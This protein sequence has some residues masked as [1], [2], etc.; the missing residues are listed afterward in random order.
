LSIVDL[1]PAGA[2][3]MASA[4]GRF[5]IA[6]N[7][8]IYNYA[9]LRAQ[10][11][12]QAWRGHSDTEVLLAAME[13]FGVPGALARCTGMFAFALWDAGA[14]HLVIG[15]D[16]LGEKPLYYGLARDALLV[17]SELKAFEAWPGFAGEIDREALDDFMRRGCVHAPRSIYRNVRKLPAG[18]LLRIPASSARDVLSAAPQVYWSLAEHAARPPQAIAADVALESLDTLLGG[19][20][21][22]QMVADVP[23]GAFLSGG[24]DS[25][26]VVA[27]MQ[28]QSIRP[29]RTYSIG[30]HE[31]GF[32]EAH[33]AKAVAAHLGTEHI[34]LY[35]TA[36]E[37]RAVIP[38][39][40]A[41]FDEPF[42]DS[43]Q[44]PTFLVAELARRSVTVSLSGDGGDELFGGYN[45]YFWAQRIWARAARFPGFVRRAAGG[46]VRSVGIGT[47][48]RMG[49]ALP[50]GVRMPQLG[51]KLHKLAGLAAMGDGR[52]AYDWLIAQY[53][54]GER[55]VTDLPNA[56]S[57]V[58]HGLWGGAGRKLADDMMLADAIGYLPDD[59][60]VKVDRATMAVSLEARAPFLDHKL[61]EF[62]FSLPLE[63][64]IRDGVGKWLLRQLLFRHVPRELIERPKMGFGVPIDAW[65]RGPLK[66][67]AGDL[68][69]PDSLRAQGF[70][71]PAP[72]ARAW[73][74]HQSGRQNN[75]HFLWNALMFQAWLAARRATPGT[76]PLP[77]MEPGAPGFW[78][79]R[80][81][82]PARTGP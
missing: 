40:P 77:R 29:V 4:S 30:F 12:A 37:A 53:R 72:I 27:L 18:C 28:R 20:I 81:P 73:G 7:G 35:V 68:L 57:L 26:L 38:R 14:R 13:A 19:A 21:A 60:L 11:P 49:R 45:R 10:L 5:T 36:A 33:H 58:G 17:G 42:G 23:V 46:A 16:R 24:I 78:T 8:E 43:S 54:G 66:Q 61:V 2:Q 41:M 64:K 39:L 65:L 15:R 3:P 69:A 80:A 48:D 82:D 62:A 79:S 55:L 56:A 70:L 1:S 50:G 52:A 22:G 71:E 47:W 74:E 31:A 6:F 51:D 25:S 63:L 9:A 75:Q 34:E 76:S 67:W 44:V 59:I 32:N